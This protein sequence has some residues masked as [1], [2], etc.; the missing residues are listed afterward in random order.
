MVQ[1]NFP[2]TFSDKTVVS[3]FCKVMPSFLTWI[4]SKYKMY[5]L[6]AIVCKKKKNLL[7]K[8]SELEIS[9]G[10]LLTIQRKISPSFFIT[11]WS[12]RARRA[13]LSGGAK[14]K[15]L[16]NVADEEVFNFPDAKQHLRLF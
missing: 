6:S 4:Q 9:S 1:K 15:S 11:P 3:K 5:N 2:L 14:K 7:K 12:M 13:T 16:K 10:E 8:S